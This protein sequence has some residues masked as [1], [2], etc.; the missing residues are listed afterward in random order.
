MPDSLKM[1]KSMGVII[2]EQEV[3][4]EVPLPIISNEIVV[5]TI[6]EQPNNFE[7]NKLMNHHSIMR[8][9]TMNRW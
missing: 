7:N 5:P 2:Y 1:V 6:V 9:P 4:V 8:Y 3:R